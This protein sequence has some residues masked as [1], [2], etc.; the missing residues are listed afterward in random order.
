MRLGWLILSICICNSLFAQKQSAATY[1]DTLYVIDSTLG[2]DNDMNTFLKTYRKQ[3]EEKMNVV[4][5]YSEVPLSKAQPECTLGILMADAQMEAAKK[6][7]KEVKISIANQG[8]IRITYLSPGPITKENVYKI[9]PF[10]NK[11]VIVEIP[12]S[13]VQQLCDLIA[14]YGGW[15]VS[16]ITFTIKNKKAIDIKV[17]GKTLNPQLIYKTAIS[18]Y[19]V[20][21]GDNVDFLADCRKTPYNIFIRDTI[22]NYIE[23][24]K[25]KGKKI[26]IELQN[27]ITYA[28]E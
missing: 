3:E 9:M 7:D 21:G 26:N 25:A 14:S 20:N 24:R 16:G 11:L 8:G 5:G 1:N 23:T 10:D 17:D 12:G 19:I 28:D 4:I 13:K 2:K 6:L 15:P 22:M 27:R 18:D